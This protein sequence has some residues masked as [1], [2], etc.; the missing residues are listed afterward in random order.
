V[1]TFESAQTLRTP[2]ASIKTHI[3]I[4]VRGYLNIHHA[5]KKKGARG[6]NNGGKVK[7]S[8]SVGGDANVRTLVQ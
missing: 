3:Y 4:Y 5:G 8:I 1:R 7:N 2:Y 6:G